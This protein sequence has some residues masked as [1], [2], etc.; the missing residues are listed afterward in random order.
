MYSKQ[1]VSREE[2]KIQLKENLRRINSIL[3]E[4]HPFHL[5][6]HIGLH[7]GVRVGEVCGLEWKHINFEEMTLEVEQQLI[8]TRMKTVKYNGNLDLQNRKL[9]IELFPLVMP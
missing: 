9:V 8:G 5:P 4:D 1:L 6:F 2:L 7:C 3:N